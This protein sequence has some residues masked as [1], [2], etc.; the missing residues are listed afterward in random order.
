MS[1]HRRGRLCSAGW[2]ML[3]RARAG[4]AGAGADLVLDFLAIGM[5]AAHATEQ[6]RAAAVQAAAEARLT[7]RT[8]AQ[9]RSEAG[10]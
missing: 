10:D 2:R 1:S 9:V 7:A 4:A 5:Q 3:R 8:R 6:A